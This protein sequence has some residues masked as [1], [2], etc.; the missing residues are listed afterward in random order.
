MAGRTRVIVVDDEVLIAEYIA[1]ELED[2]GFEV[3]EVCRSYE[4]AI[5]A[6]SRHDPDLVIL[7]ISIGRGGSGLDLARNIMVSR[8]AKVIFCSGMQPSEAGPEF[9]RCGLLMKPFT[10]ADL[11]RVVDRTLAAA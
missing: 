3:C 1:G 6:V 2:A 11:M 9:A 10:P 4:D 8:R 7:D 5:E